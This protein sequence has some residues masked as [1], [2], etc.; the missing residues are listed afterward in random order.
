MEILTRFFI[1]LTLIRLIGGNENT[2]FI[3][4]HIDNC[5]LSDYYDVN[6][7]LCRQ[8]DSQLNLVPSANGKEFALFFIIFFRNKFAEIVETLIKKL[9]LPKKNGKWPEN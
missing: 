4:N 7:F 9:I 6:Y 8:C 2:V 5:K 1:I 3:Y